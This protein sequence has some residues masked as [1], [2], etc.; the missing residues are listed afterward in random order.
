MLA[1]VACGL[2]WCMVVGGGAEA[3]DGGDLQTTE[4]RKSI[5]AALTSGTSAGGVSSLVV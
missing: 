3:L 4:C 1:V 2:A 5:W